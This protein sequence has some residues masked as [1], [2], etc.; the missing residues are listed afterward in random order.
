LINFIIAVRLKFKQNGCGR[1]A[2]LQ[3]LLIRT[4]TFLRSSTQ[5]LCDTPI[6]AFCRYSPRRMKGSIGVSP[7]HDCRHHWDLNPPV[8]HFLRSKIYRQVTQNPRAIPFG[9]Q[10]GQPS[11]VQNSFGTSVINFF[12]FR[13]VHSYVRPMY[14]VIHIFKASV[15][16]F[17]FWTLA[18]EGVIQSTCR[19]PTT[20]GF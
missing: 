10:P 2:L 5:R 7:Y 18:G 3:S 19:Q 9:R 13:D 14:I 20:G 15:S 1:Y 6:D 17:F 16:I 4:V 8:Y 12:K 11:R